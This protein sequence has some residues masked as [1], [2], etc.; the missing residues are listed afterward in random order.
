MSPLEKIHIDPA[1]IDENSIKKVAS[2]IRQGK[3]VALPTETVYGLAANLDNKETL[4]RL[5]GIKK[6]PKDMPF[7]VHIGR[8]Q[9]VDFFFDC[10]PV[11]G[12]KIIEKF[13]P[14]PLTI[15]YHRKDSVET[16]GVRCPDNKVTSLILEE[17]L[18]KVVMPSANISG[19]P[20]AVSA[21]EVEKVFSD[22]IDCIVTSEEPKLK[23]SSTVLDLSKSPFAIL[24]RGKITK[25]DIEN[26]VKT[27][28]VLFVCTGNTCRSVMAEYLLKNYLEVRR[29]DLAGKI[30][31][32]SC[33]AH[34]MD[35]M[36]A[37]EG[38]AQVLADQGIDASKHKAK[39]I[40]RNLVRSSDIIIVMEKRHRDSVM[41][42]ESLGVS[43]TFL[44]SSF[45]KNYDSD[46][47]DPIGGS[48]EDYKK[49]FDL[50][51]SAVEEIVEWL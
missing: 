47:P 7:T 20:P 14:G 40:T 3:I 32:T 50:I 23:V 42:A 30:G 5:Y 36:P 27:R 31:I 28:R 51:R 11:Y 13:W 49:G 2:F 29:K 17:S 41:Q 39:K 25:E 18:C 9:D 16:I 12:Y 22:K 1:N 38:A 24:R 33:G 10:L 44:M 21:Q 8:P 6:R 15:V 34:A 26:A 45:L 35:G 19:D 4:L 37:S 46:I 48:K 43:R